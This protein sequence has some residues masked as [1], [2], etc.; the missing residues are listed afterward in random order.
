MLYVREFSFENDIMF[1]RLISLLL[2]SL[3]YCICPAFVLSIPLQFALMYIHTRT[4]WD[5]SMMAFCVLYLFIHVVCFGEGISVG[6]L[7]LIHNINYNL[8]GVLSKFW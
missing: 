2:P 3:N 8:F 4:F 5:V 7:I 1:T 6:P